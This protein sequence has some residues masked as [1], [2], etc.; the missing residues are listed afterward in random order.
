MKASLLKNF[1]L[2]LL[3]FAMLGGSLAQAQSLSVNINEDS[4]YSCMWASVTLTPQLS[5]QQGTVNW[6][7]STGDTTATIYL[8]STTVGNDTV[9][10]SVSDTTG[11][12]AHDTVVII[13]LP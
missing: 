13:V 1:T 6:N 10:V 8:L 12:V 5:G 4:V 9:V 7:W 3:V 2:P 11:A